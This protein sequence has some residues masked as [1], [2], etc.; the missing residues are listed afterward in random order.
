METILQSKIFDN[1]YIS[2]FLVTI[3]VLYASLLGPKLPPIM[4]TL[5]DNPI[6][7]III[8]FMLVVRGNADPSL[9]IMVV[10]VF[11]LT[12]DFLNTENE[13][14]KFTNIKKNLNK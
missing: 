12:L 3:L 10:I 11:V 5:F 8:L 6:F 4:K 13:I 2:T 14:E 7:K 1:V 9:A